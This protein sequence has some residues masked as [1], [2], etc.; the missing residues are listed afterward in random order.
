MIEDTSLIIDGLHDSP[1]ALGYL[2]LAEKENHPENID[3]YIDRHGIASLATAL[4]YAVDRERG[5][6]THRLMARDLA[7]RRRDYPAGTPT[8]DHR[9]LR[10]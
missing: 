10:R 1:D 7:A 6:I 3:T 5:E 8:S 2:D 9:T 4:T